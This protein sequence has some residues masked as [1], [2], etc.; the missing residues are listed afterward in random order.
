MNLPWYRLNCKLRRPHLRKA[1]YLNSRKSP[2]K[3]PRP[4]KF[5]AGPAQD[6]ARTARL[7]V[8][9]LRPAEPLCLAARRPGQ[10]GAQLTFC[11]EHSW[12]LVRKTPDLVTTIF[13]TPYSRQPA[14]LPLVPTLRKCVRTGTRLGFPAE[15]AARE[16]RSFRCS[17]AA[18]HRRLRRS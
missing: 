10:P 8:A 1:S 15:T 18:L 4:T 5:R 7:H 2:R 9:P 12:S 17:A 13:P 3:P 16:N 11:W 14:R 6:H